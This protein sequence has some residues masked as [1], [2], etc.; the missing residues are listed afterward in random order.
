MAIGILSSQ[1]GVGRFGV[2][3]PNASMPGGSNPQSPSD[4][5]VDTP[6]YASGPAWV[7]VLLVVGYI[8]VSQTL[9]Q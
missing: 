3:P 1:T 5:G 2:R 4:A 6:W 7:L 8:L 9:K